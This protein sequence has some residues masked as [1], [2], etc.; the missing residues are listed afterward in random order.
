[1]KSLWL[2]VETACSARCV[3]A[4]TA[5]IRERQLPQLARRSGGRHYYIR[6]LRDMKMG[7]EI[8]TFWAQRLI[9]A[10]DVAGWTMARTHAISGDAVLISGY[11][12]KSEAFDSALATSHEF[13]RIKQSKIIKRSAVKSGKLPV[14]ET[15][16]ELG[17]FPFGTRMYSHSYICPLHIRYS[18]P[19]N[20]L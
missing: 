19:G 15:I 1:M 10:A 3:G 17:F 16:I 7:P 4:A 8:G 2:L 12:G 11:L 20:E 18:G 5:S 13:T 6:Q 14:N 9:E